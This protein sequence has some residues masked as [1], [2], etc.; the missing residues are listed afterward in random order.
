[1]EAR[2]FCHSTGMNCPKDDPD[3]RAFLEDAAHHDVGR[4][5]LSI[6]VRNREGVRSLV[7]FTSNRSKDDWAEYKSRN[8]VK[9]QPVAVL[10]DSAAGINFKLTP[11]PVELSKREEECLI[12]AAR[13]KTYHDIAG[14]LN[15]SFASVKTYL[16]TARHKLSCINL[17]HAV[18]IATGVIPAKALRQPC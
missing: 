10:I 2:L 15:L 7:S 6:P 8:M 3:V 18:A 17:T 14:I 16:D 4:N 12:W 1:M 9:L 5:G 11:E 13:G